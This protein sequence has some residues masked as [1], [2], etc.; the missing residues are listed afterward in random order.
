M[1]AEGEPHLDQAGVAVFIEHDVSIAA[2]ERVERKV[3]F[4]DSEIGYA[5]G[6]QDDDLLSLIS[7]AAG[8]QA[9]ELGVARDGKLQIPANVASDLARAT[10]ESL[11]GVIGQHA[12][13]LPCQV[14]AELLRRSEFNSPS[15]CW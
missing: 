10:V 7:P 14:M 5:A 2:L 12:M 1:P 8:H 15:S 6:S 3:N 11:H 4:V 13:P 9:D